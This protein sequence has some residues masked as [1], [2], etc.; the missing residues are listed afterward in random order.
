M[1]DRRFEL[2]CFCGFGAEAGIAEGVVTSLVKPVEVKT[3]KRKQEPAERSGQQVKR[4]NDNG[5]GA[6]L[7]N[8]RV[9][10]LAKQVLS[11]DVR[12]QLPDPVS[13]VPEYPS[14]WFYELHVEAGILEERSEAVVR[15][16]EEMV[17]SP[18]DGPSLRRRQE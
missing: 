7:E 11:E 9:I 6:G 16:I 2:S 4:S 14:A 3:G 12:R 8:D 17:G 13:E 10:H 18:V 1:G 5:H 15:E